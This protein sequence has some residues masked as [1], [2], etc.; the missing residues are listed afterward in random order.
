MDIELDHPDVAVACF[1]YPK[2][3][4]GQSASQGPAQDCIID[5]IDEFSRE[6]ADRT[7]PGP[8]R[9]LALKFLIHFVGD[10]HQ[11]LHASD[12]HDKGGNCVRLDPSPDGDV[13][14]LHAF[15]D[16]TVV[17]AQGGSAA[18]I[19]AKLNAQITPAEVKR[20]SAG[21]AADWALES[22]RM[23]K[24]DVYRLPS[25]PACEGGAPIAL[26][27]DYQA[28]A[29]RDAAI[30]LQQ[31]GVR[32]AMLLNHAFGPVAVN[33]AAALEREA[34]VMGAHAANH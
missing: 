14:N 27:S 17:K 4:A 26:S 31:A 13:R 9:L 20:W 15:W 12:D 11:P 21:S 28:M 10:I 3:P 18:D 24:A 5:K 30:R 1:G 32:M 2:I 8:E 29:S 22:Y 7:T 34:D 33:N 19:A 16:V 6:L 23:A 25:W